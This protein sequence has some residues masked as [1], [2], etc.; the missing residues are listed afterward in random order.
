MCRSGC[1]AVPWVATLDLTVD[2]RANRATAY[3]DVAAP[4]EGQ[5]LTRVNWLLRQLREAPDALRIEGF[6][7]GRTGTA[8]LLREL[9]TEPKRLIPDGAKEIKAF[10]VAHSR[11]LGSGRGRGRGAFIDSVLDTIDDAYTEIG[12]RLRAWTAT[13]PRLRSDSEVEVET[14]IPAD[15]PS[16]AISSRDDSLSGVVE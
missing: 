4:R 15:L 6:A 2:L 9:R 1:S 3:F 11:Q 14:D 16:N 7:R 10:R 8:A 5:P 12:Q 13:P